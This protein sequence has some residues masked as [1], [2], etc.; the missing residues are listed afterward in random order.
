MGNG[1]KKR[2]WIGAGTVVL[3]LFCALAVIAPK[4]VDSAWLKATLKAQVAKQ[5]AGEF[6]FQKAD[7]I[8]LP[9][10][11]VSL[12]QVS[13]S[14]PASAQIHLDN[15]KVY[16]RLFP[17]L[18]GKISLDKIVIDKPD[19]SLPLPKRSA[20]RTKE[21][22]ASSHTAFPENILAELSPVLAPISNLD[23]GLEQGTLRLFSGDAQ[24][25]LVED[26]NG[27]FKISGKSLSATISS[28]RALHKNEKIIAQVKN[29]KGSILYS[30]QK[31][32][33]TVED[34]TFSYPR[35]Q[36]SGIYTFDQT[37]P[38]ASLEIKSQNADIGTLRDALPAIINALYG[39][40]PVIRQIFDITRGGTVS[41]ASFHV[42]GKSPG[43]LA[44]FESMR[45]Q[46]HIQNGDI[47]LENL[48]LDLQEVTG[49]V[50]IA[51]TILAG[52]NLEARLGNSH[53]SGGSL[54]F[55]LV[56]KEKTPFHLD[57][58][59]DADLAEVP[60]LLEQLI[61]NEKITR[62][63]SLFDNIAGSGRGRI[64]L[65]DKL[66]SLST[67][68]EVN[69]IAVTGNFK[70]IP[71][72]F[73]IDSGRFVYEG[74]ETQTFDLQGKVGRST[75]SDY[76]SRYNWEGEPGIDVQSG[77]FHLA[78]DE[79]FP[80]LASDTKLKEELQNIANITGRADIT[81]KSLKGPLLKPAQLQ[82][83]L[84]C[85]LNDVTL[86]TPALPGPLK[87]TKGKAHFIPNKMVFENLQAGLQ[88]S[89]LT[90][91]AVLRNFISGKTNADKFAPRAD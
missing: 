84:L 38:H 85:D 52:N 15:L 71:Y 79:I 21:V 35:V 80:W 39:E 49:D 68:V 31:S 88:D 75:F 47:F 24:V 81:I 83:D 56:P 64:I 59:L 8:I 36:L 26:I 22:K 46:A 10:P 7:L 18:I 60:P 9:Y 44:V 54:K 14:I 89:S 63:L 91:S 17:L 70:P 87:I 48:G 29:F 12:H 16:P 62:Y 41:Q 3:L 61:S 42:E 30:E 20:V 51:N 43:D 76:S 55:G 58:D 11:V 82:Y 72:P 28:L 19:L 50:N 86:S 78:L 13:L 45:I 67:R 40:Q 90:Y 73:T 53:G 25:L 32:L 57:L 74:L 33:L 6:D 4:V 37:A 77:T 5:V 27:E 66:E 2:F 1:L 34:L 65:G 23:I 69:E